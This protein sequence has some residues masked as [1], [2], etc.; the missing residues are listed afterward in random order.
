MSIVSSYNDNDIIRNRKIYQWKNSCCR[1]YWGI[2]IFFAEKTALYHAFQTAKGDSRSSPS[3]THFYWNREN[4]F[5]INI[6]IWSFFDTPFRSR[7]KAHLLRHCWTILHLPHVWSSSVVLAAL[8]FI[9]GRRQGLNFL[10]FK[11]M[12]L[13]WW[14]SKILWIMRV[15]IVIFLFFQD[16][17]WF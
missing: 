14:P 6:A 5:P 4:L 17:I 10:N 7:P 9:E 3:F 16:Q 11:F 1:I 8:F 15:L 2:C 13:V 12:I